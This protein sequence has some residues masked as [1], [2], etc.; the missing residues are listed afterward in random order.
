[1]ADQVAGEEPGR[2]WQLRVLHQ[3]ARR[4][5]GLVPATVALEE[6]AR[7]VTDDIVVGYATT[8]T[9]KAIW[10]AGLPDRFSALRRSAETTQELSDRYPV[11][12]LG[13][14]EGHG[15]RS[16]VRGCQLTAEN[17][18]VARWLRRVS[19]QVLENRMET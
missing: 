5:R 10:P 19:N 13:L 17:V 7:T 9:T 3:A 11:L 15:L 2:Q 8:R 1:M 14:V 12:E 18:L 4:Q 16:A 6:L